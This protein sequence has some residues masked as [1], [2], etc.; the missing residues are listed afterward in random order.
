MTEMC[1]RSTDANGTDAH[2]GCGER[3]IGNNPVLKHPAAVLV[4][5]A[6]PV[7]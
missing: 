5:S 4:S 6:P 1:L 3:K 7:P 2:D